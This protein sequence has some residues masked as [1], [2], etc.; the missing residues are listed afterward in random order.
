MASRG[1]DSEAGGGVALGVEVDQKRAAAA[2]GE[3]RAEVDGGG[4]FSHAAFLI[5]YAQYATH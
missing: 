3:A 4:R 1:L 2:L 5:R